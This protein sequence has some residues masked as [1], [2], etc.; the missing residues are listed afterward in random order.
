MP[1]EG[2][3]I[4]AAGVVLTRPGRRG[5]Q[6]AVVHRPHRLDWSLP[7]GKVDPGEHLL[8]AAVRECD[9]ETGI[10]PRLGPPL[11]TQYYTALG[12]P[13][14]V[15][16]WRADVNGDE[17]FAPDDEVDEV[18]WVH[19]TEAAELLTYPRDVDLIQQAIDLPLTTPLIVLR[20]TK[21]LKRVDFKGTDDQLRPLSG[22][23]R[24]QAKAL[25]PLLGAYGIR[26]LHA[27]DATRCQESL[28]RYAQATDLPI[29]PEPYL[30]EEGHD[31]HPKRA[32]RRLLELMSIRKP[33]VVCTHR[34]V[35]PTLM[36][37]LAGLAGGRG[38]DQHHLDPKLAPGEFIV[39][40]RHFDGGQQPRV[41]AI[42]RHQA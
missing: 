34:P 23:G 1:G 9:E 15:F 18:R 40:H 3:P 20:H 7:K 36:T 12:L 16:Y 13:K 4:I 10:V 27:S 32:A 31:E 39:L 24:S 30:S 19:L 38:P 41:I 21:A 14:K 6:I 26:E 5:P 2:T 37:E 29:E 33:L 11:E 42:E 25:V 35:L 28:R 8:H 22:K 17:G